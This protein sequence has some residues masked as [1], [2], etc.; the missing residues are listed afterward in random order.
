MIINRYAN[1]PEGH[2]HGIFDYLDE[3]VF[4]PLNL[5]DRL[6]FIRLWLTKRNGGHR[7]K[8]VRPGVFTG[9][10]NPKN[11]YACIDLLRDRGVDTFAY[12]HSADYFYFSVSKGQARWAEYILLRSGIGEQLENPTDWRSENTR[13]ATASIGKGA[14]PAWKHQ[15]QGRRQRHQRPERRMRA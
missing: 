14:P 9:E 2:R 15:A 7:F 12:T 1:A 13:G 5:I 3:Y 6:G 4:G 10:G 8:L 11:F